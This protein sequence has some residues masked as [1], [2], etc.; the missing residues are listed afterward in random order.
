[1][2][3]RAEFT[4]EPFTEGRQGPHVQAAIEALAPLSPDIGPFGTAVEGDL[5]VVL[6]RAA[7][8]IRAAMEAGATRVAVTMTVTP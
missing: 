8:G 4:V 7:A 3:A 6:D 2:L 5:D 1:M